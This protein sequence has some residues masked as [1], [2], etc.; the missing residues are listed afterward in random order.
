MPQNVF[1]G[2]ILSGGELRDD[3]KPN[4]VLL[5]VTRVY[6]TDKN[7]FHL[8]KIDFPDWL[9]NTTHSVLQSNWEKIKLKLIFLWNLT[10]FYRMKT[11]DRWFWIA[12]F[13]VGKP[14]LL[15]FVPNKSTCRFAD[16][17]INELFFSRSVKITPKEISFYGQRITQFFKTYIRKEGIIATES[18][19]ERIMEKK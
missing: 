2:L 14:W 9:N 7:Q 4:M 15:H 11:A 8:R 6:K 10:R 3:Y 17:C 12:G 5:V 18:H 19:S 13:G 1:W 16:L